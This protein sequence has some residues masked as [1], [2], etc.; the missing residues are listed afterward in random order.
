M[1]HLCEDRS[2]DA[3]RHQAADKAPDGKAKPVTKGEAPGR[4]PDAPPAGG[5][6]K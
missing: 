1:C 4:A 2:Y 6:A 5:A 3:F